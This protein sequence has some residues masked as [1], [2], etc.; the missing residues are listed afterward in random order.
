MIVPIKLCHYVALLSAHLEIRITQNANLLNIFLSFKGVIFLPL[1]NERPGDKRIF[2]TPLGSLD[3][4]LCMNAYHQ[5]LH[6]CGI[7]LQA[8]PPRYPVTSIRTHIL[9]PDI[10]SCCSLIIPDVSSS[11]PLHLSLCLEGGDSWRLRLKQRPFPSA[12]V[13]SAETKA[14]HFLSPS[15]KSSMNNPWLVDPKRS[16][17]VTRSE[18]FFSSSA[19]SSMNQPR[20]LFVR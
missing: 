4:H 9:H 12:N 14:N 6:R 10:S 5:A 11:I 19:C 20:N 7:G 2:H 13:F 8:P 3:N 18:A 17:S 15:F 1:I 16:Y